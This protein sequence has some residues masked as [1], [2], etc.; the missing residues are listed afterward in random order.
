M[1]IEAAWYAFKTGVPWLHILAA[2]VDSDMIMR[3]AQWVL[4]VVLALIPLRIVGQR[5]APAPRKVLK[6]RTA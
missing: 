1:L 3:P 4:I 5:R 6:A 2:N